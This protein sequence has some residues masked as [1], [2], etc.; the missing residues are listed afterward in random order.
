MTVDTRRL[1]SNLVLQFME[2]NFQ[3]KNQRER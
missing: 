2:S 3:I 1:K